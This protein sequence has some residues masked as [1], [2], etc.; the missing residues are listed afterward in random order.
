MSSPN[1]RSG[2]VPAPA[3]YQQQQQPASRETS[4][5]DASFILPGDSIGRVNGASY[6][7]AT[8]S[9]CRYFGL[10]ARPHGVVCRAS[11][12]FCCCFFLFNGPR[13]GVKL[14]NLGCRFYACYLIFF[15]KLVQSMKLWSL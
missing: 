8:V 13:G 10:L 2:Y 15:C 9:G 6:C 3:T 7:I 14:S 4:F 11:C 12:I 5:Q 1:P